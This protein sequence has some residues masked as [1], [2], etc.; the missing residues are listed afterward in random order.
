MVAGICETLRWTS[1]RYS[2]GSPDIYQTQAGA[3][4]NYAAYRRPT[5]CADV[6]RLVGLTAWGAGQRPQVQPQYAETHL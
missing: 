2:E 3:Q 6:T 1:A 5:L 4:Y